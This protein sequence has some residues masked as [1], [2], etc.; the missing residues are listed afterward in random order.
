MDYKQSIGAVVRHFYEHH[1]EVW[2]FCPGCHNNYKPMVLSEFGDTDE[3]IANKIIDQLYETRLEF[4]MF[5]SDN[6][7]PG[8]SFHGPSLYIDNSY[9]PFPDGGKPKWIKGSL[10]IVKQVPMLRYYGDDKRMFQLGSRPEEFTFTSQFKGQNDFDNYLKY[11]KK[12]DELIKYN[13]EIMERFEIDKKWVAAYE[14][15][16]A[17]KLDFD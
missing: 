13:T 3:E 6:S 8:G 10:K 5:S 7:H 9:C 15:Q 16:E 14:L 2:C 12:T 1:T 11:L 17:I 4:E